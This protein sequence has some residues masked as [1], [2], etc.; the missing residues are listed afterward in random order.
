MQI[1]ILLFAAFLGFVLAR[2]FGQ[3]A[4][5]GEIL[6][7]ILIGP[8]VLGWIQFD[9]VVAILAELGAVFLLFTVGLECN[10]KHIYT[11]KNSFVGL[12]G[13]IVPFFIGWWLANIFG[14]TSIEALFIAVSLTATS[15]A[16]TA[17]VLAERN[18]LSAK[19]AKTILG[20][21]VVD[22][23]LSLL[24]LSVVIGL[25]GETGAAAIS[26]QAGIAVAFVVV[27]LLLIKPVN[28][29]I[30]AIDKHLAAKDA[31]KVTL[32][33][34]MIIAFG[35]AGVAELIG[36]SSIV[37]AFIAGVSMES[38]HIPHLRE[39]A[40]YFEMLF[41]AIFF[42]SLGVLTNI[43]QLQGA[44]TFAIILTLVA[45]VTK[46]I[47]CM[48]PALLT[49]HTLHESLLIGFGM[50]PRGEVAMIVGLLGLSAGIIS[51]G[52]YGVI[53]LMAFVTT[54]IAPPILDLMLPKRAHPSLF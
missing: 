18:L 4:V 7:G 31:H 49:K 26:L 13:V 39:G 32:F 53:I 27:T 10:Y 23:I 17:H 15:I 37:G 25:N 43:S 6:L 47:G 46:L 21:A 29:L 34:T 35:Y 28:K 14:Y 48:I 42:V 8:S 44:W 51:Q 50:V 30:N 20:A 41:S 45:I 9:E 52:T 3:S 19:F 54:I 1:T 5:I 12:M 24:A 38:L 11:L 22:D 36:L 40:A 16:I 2:K 33:A